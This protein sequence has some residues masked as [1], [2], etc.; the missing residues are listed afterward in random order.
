MTWRSPSGSRSESGSCSDSGSR[1]DSSRSAA[2]HSS[3]R[4][5]APDIARAVRP[6]AT[7]TK[8]G[9]LIPMSPNSYVSLSETSE[10]TGNIAF[11]GIE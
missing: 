7:N 1:R 3:R 2:T 8:L 9:R 11:S 4:R 5:Q 6:R 10:I